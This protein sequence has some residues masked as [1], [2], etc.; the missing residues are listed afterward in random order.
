[1]TAKEYI[2]SFADANGFWDREKACQ[3]YV[4]ALGANDVINQHMETGNTD[5]IINLQV[6][7]WL[8]SHLPF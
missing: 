2:E 7:L 6:S 3:A 4:I 1:M 8:L 5:D